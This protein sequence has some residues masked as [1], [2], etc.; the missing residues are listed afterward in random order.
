[1]IR[2]RYVHWQEEEHYLGYCEDFPD[3]RTQ[4][5]TPQELLENLRDLYRDIASGEIPSI[6]KVDELVLTE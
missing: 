2:L 1:M 5:R 4:G 3:Y 6:K